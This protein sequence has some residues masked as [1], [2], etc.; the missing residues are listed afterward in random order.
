MGRFSN[1]QIDE[2]N[3]NLQQENI[4]YGELLIPNDEFKSIVEQFELIEKNNNS[5]QLTMVDEHKFIY[6]F[7]IHG[8]KQFTKTEIEKLINDKQTS[9]YDGVYVCCYESK[10]QRFLDCL[11]SIYDDNSCDCAS[12]S[13]CEIHN[14]P[15]EDEDFFCSLCN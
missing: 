15:L 4:L 14:R 6:K 13:D 5:N 11:N 12:Y 7:G 2:L 10:E 9:P 1:M 8:E 3:N